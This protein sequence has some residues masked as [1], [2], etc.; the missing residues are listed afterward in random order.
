MQTLWI[1]L[2][3]IWKF[4]VVL[5]AKMVMFNGTPDPITSY[6]TSISW[7]STGTMCAEACEADA[8]CVLS[9]W[10]ISLNCYLYSVG[11]VV[12]IEMDVGETDQV[13]FKV[14]LSYLEKRRRELGVSRCL[15]LSFS[16]WRHPSKFK[17]V[18][19][20]KEERYQEHLFGEK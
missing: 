11:D 16:H 5:P 13:A 7:I 17:P 14:R 10:N 12:W 20:K 3:F 15:R 1:I 9:F 6:P 2:L 4:R 8:Y 18:Y 19:R